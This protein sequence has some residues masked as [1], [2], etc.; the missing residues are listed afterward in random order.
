M[1]N[2][3]TTSNVETVREKFEEP[4][5]TMGRAVIQQQIWR[6]SMMIP[7]NA[8]SLEGVLLH[9]GTNEFGTYKYAIMKRFFA[10]TSNHN[11]ISYFDKLPLGRI[12]G[13]SNCYSAEDFKDIIT[14]VFGKSYCPIL[15]LDGNKLA[16]GVGDP[17]L[18][19]TAGVLYFKDKDF[20][21]SIKDSQI[22]ISFYKYTG[23]KGTFG[24]DIDGGGE[25]PFRDNMPHFI[26][27]EN[28]TNTATFKVRGDKDNTNYVLPP[29]NGK[30]YDKKD[31]ADTAVLVTQENIEDVIWKENVKI[32]GGAWVP[33]EGITKVYRH[34]LPSD[35]EED[36]S[37]N[38]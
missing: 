33:V 38:R 7:E 26:N 4:I 14:D 8:P 3:R 22:S 6:D 34:G 25:L 23:R 12:K 29:D 17:I 2:K 18:D 1:E 20:V 28:L 32:S 24:S 15:F 5:E 16:Y 27:S 21:E 35:K 9:D 13:T 31:E 10:G 19:E 11:L 30:W 36:A 37:T